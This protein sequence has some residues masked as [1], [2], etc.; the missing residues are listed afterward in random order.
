[1]S[2][3]NSVL[4]IATSANLALSI[5]F[6]A[7]AFTEVLFGSVGYALFSFVWGFVAGAVAYIGFDYILKHPGEFGMTDL[8]ERIDSNVGNH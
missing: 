5:L 6:V 8:Q 2:K 1:M 4:T 3:W 7:Q